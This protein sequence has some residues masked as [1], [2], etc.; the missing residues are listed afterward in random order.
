[1]INILIAACCIALV[2]IFALSLYI[3]KLKTHIKENTA[4][5]TPSEEL[6]HF[7]RDVKTHGY[8]FVRVNPDHVFMRTPGEL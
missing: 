5:Q 8:G 3:V 2:I 6:T 4:K 1:M 7:L